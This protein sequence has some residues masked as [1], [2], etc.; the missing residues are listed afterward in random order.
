M[1]TFGT[2]NLCFFEGKQYCRLVSKWELSSCLRL[3]S[4]CFKTFWRER[5]SSFPFYGGVLLSLLLTA[6]VTN[7]SVQLTASLTIWPWPF[8]APSKEDR[9]FEAELCRMQA[10]CHPL[11]LAFF[12]LDII[13]LLRHLCLCP[14]TFWEVK[15]FPPV[16]F[17]PAIEYFPVSV[18]LVCSL[19]W[20]ECWN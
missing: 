14:C 13:K 10:S 18:L 4:I 11:H 17:D 9:R 15:I 19:A 5:P 3:S 20:A 2:C 16:A 6:D 12:I 8:W 7:W 1:Q